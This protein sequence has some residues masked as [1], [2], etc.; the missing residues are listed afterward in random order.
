[1]TRHLPASRPGGCL[2]RLC[3]EGSFKRAFSSVE[4]VLSW[5]WLSCC[6]LSGPKLCVFRVFSFAASCLDGACAAWGCRIAASS[7]TFS[8]AN[9]INHTTGGVGASN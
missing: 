4:A 6:L 3:W 5:G 9:D 2:G 7:I 8:R 1:M